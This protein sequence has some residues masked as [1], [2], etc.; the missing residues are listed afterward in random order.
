MTAQTEWF[1][2]DELSR[3]RWQWVATLR[4]YGRGSRT[5]TLQQVHSAQEA[6]VA[7]AGR[8]RGRAHSGG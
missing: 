6:Y 4:E 1:F 3:L 2:E 5:A 8:L 7:R